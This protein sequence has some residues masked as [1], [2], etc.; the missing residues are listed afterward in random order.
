ME[1]NDSLSAD[2]FKRYLDSLDSQKLF[3]SQADINRFAPYRT[4][5]DDAI[6]SQQL[7]PAYDIHR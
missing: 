3:F 1:L 5:L 2:I 4:G 6:E 7:Q